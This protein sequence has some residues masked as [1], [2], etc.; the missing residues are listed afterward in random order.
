MNNNFQKH[1]SDDVY[2]FGATKYADAIN[3]NNI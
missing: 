3:D 2:A 1:T